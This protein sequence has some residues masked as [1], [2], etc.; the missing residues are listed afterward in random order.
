MYGKTEFYILGIQI[1][2]KTYIS[3]FVILTSGICNLILNFLLI[4][5]YGMYGATFAT[6][7]SYIIIN[8]LYIFIAIPMINIRFNFYKTFIY[9]LI[10]FIIYLLYL[11]FT[12]IYD[13][14]TFEII[15][16]MILL[17]IYILSCIKLKLIKKDY[18]NKVLIYIK[19]KLA[20]F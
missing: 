1:R 14:I 12:K 10:S 19:T 5:K 15:F 11:S 13:N 20:L 4:P 9:Y 18:I 7:I 6:L 16:S 2:N 17:I 3:S 8:F